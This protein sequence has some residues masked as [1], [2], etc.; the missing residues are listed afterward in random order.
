MVENFSNLGWEIGIQIHEG[1]L[2]DPKEVEPKNGLHQDTWQL[3]WQNSKTEFWKQQEKR[4]KLHKREPPYNDQW[5]FQQN[6]R[7]GWCIQNIESKKAV[8]QEYHNRQSCLSQ[9]RDKGIP[10][11]TK[12][13]EF[14]TRI[15]TLQYMLKN[16]LQAEIFKF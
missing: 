7:V 16:I 5:I 1:G 13:W 11:Q 3:N 2:K 14:I 8:N 15:L 9:M 10:K 4:N 12:L 6:R